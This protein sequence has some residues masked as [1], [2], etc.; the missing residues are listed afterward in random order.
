MVVNETRKMKK[1]LDNF[2]IEIQSSSRC[3]NS[4]NKGLKIQHILKSPFPLILTFL[5]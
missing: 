5:V 3:S 1:C 4:P 2:D